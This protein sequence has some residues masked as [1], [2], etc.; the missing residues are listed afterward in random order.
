MRL[1]SL[2]AVVGSP[3]RDRGRRLRLRLRR[4]VH[5]LG[6]E[7]AA[8]PGC[9]RVTARRRHDSCSRWQASSVTGGPTAPGSTS[10]GVRHGQHASRDHRPRRRGSAARGRERPL[11]GHAERRDLQLRR[12]AGGARS[13]GLASPQLGHGGARRRLRGV[14]PATASIASTATSR[15][16]S[17]TGSRASSSSPAI[18]S[19]PGR[20]SWRSSAAT[21]A[22]RRSARRSCAIRRHAVSSIRPR[23]SSRSRP[24]PSSPTAPRSRAS[25]SS[26]RRTT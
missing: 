11:L 23:S 22:S 25:G 21:S 6:A 9:I 14:G 16:R 20:S 19:A 12:A 5:I 3:V 2:A 26:P 17:G 7:C 13:L 1:A 15:S 10:T 4:G 18:A 8:S 24:G